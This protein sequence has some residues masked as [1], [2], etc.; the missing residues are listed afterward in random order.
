MIRVDFRCELCREPQNDVEIDPETLDVTCPSCEHTVNVEV[1]LGPD[2]Q[3]LLLERDP[4]L[5]EEPL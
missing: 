3:V 5:E 1:Y 4:P 2:L